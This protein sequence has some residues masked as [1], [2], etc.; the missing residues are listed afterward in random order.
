LICPQETLL[1]QRIRRV[2][3][4]GQHKNDPV[5]AALM[6]T[7]DGA[8]P[9]R[10]YFD[11]SLGSAAICAQDVYQG[12]FH[13]IVSAAASMDECERRRFTLKPS[14]LKAFRVA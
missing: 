7:D 10:R 4:F 11:Y 2:A 13:R 14:F 8:E 5:H 3:I 12:R 9:V 1:G 6:L